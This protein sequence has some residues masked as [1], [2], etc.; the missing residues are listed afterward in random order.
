MVGRGPAQAVIG[1]R[2]PFRP[3]G[4]CDLSL[5]FVPVM[6]GVQTHGRILRTSSAGL[7][8]DGMD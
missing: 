2:F 7:T 4:F 5:F 8:V 6:S 1:R 3:W